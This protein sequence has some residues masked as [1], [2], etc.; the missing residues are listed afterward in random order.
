MGEKGREEGKGETRKQDRGADSGMSKT[1]E[2][3]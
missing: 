2:M 1:A 3:G